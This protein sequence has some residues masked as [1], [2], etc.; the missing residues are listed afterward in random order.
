[1]RSVR[2]S[3]CNQ[4]FLTVHL[5]IEKASLQ[6]TRVWVEPLSEGG[7]LAGLMRMFHRL[8]FPALREKSCG[9]H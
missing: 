6:G 9:Q 5:S 3:Q 1:M 8:L 2:L 7:G 4:M